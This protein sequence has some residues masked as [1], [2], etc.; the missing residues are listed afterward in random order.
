MLN[1]S[2]QRRIGTA[3]FLPYFPS[4]LAAFVH[5]SQM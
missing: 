3:L 5:R 1:L 2:D 4:R